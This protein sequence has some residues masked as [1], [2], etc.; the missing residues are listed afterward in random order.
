[1]G[2]VGRGRAGT[3]VDRNGAALLVCVPAPEGFRWAVERAGERLE[4]ESVV[5]AERELM[6]TREVI[7]L[8]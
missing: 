4:F 8:G 5:D 2:I 6:K 7:A 1:M 3:V